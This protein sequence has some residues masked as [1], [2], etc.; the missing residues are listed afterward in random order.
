MIKAD[1]I[2]AIGQLAK[3]HGIKGEIT[4]TLDYDLDLTELSCIVVGI[5]NIFVPFFIE[6]VRPKSSESVIIAIDGITDERL[7]KEICGQTYYALKKDVDIDDG[8]SN[9]GGYIS[10]FVG[11][12]IIDPAGN[13]VA[14]ITGWDDSTENLLFIC[15]SGDKTVYIPIA[16]DLIDDIDN[17]N[18]T[19][20]MTI[21]EGLLEL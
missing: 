6:N 3:P 13:V 4:A 21:P 8:L 11:Y 10:D 1:E 15:K 5:D 14:E 7:A 16:E 19:I 17:D 2:I 20:T 12:D 18:K 9:E